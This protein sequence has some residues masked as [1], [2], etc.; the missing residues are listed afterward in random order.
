LPEGGE[1]GRRAVLL[2]VQFLV[3][4]AQPT[5]QLVLEPPSAG[6]DPLA[7]LMITM[8]AVWI[9][10]VPWLRLCWWLGAQ[11]RRYATS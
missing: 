10:G 9:L 4:F 8:A 1:A 11:A 5:L 3:G 2:L 7:A 6:A